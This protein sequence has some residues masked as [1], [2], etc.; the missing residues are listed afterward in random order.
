[1][2]DRV[3]VIGTGVTGVGLVAVTLISDH[4]VIWK[5]RSMAGLHA[6]LKE[7][8]ISLYRMLHKNMEQDNAEI[9]RLLAGIKCTTDYVDLISCNLVLESVSE[10]ILIKRQVIEQVEQVCNVETVI[11][12]NTSSLLISEIA[13][14]S[15]IPE[16]I[17]GMHFFNP[18]QKMRLVEL[19]HT[20][21]TDA[22]AL[23]CAR[24]YIKRVNKIHINALD[25]SGFVVNRLLLLMLNEACRMLEKNVASVLDIDNAMEYGAGHPMGIFALADLIGLDI[26]LAALNNLYYHYG[27]AYKPTHTLRKM[28]EEGNLGRKSGLGFHDYNRAP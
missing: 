10:D 27:N 17:I 9:K 12:S 21:K 6:G 25:S 11:A 18:I 26:C 19:V 24:E 14:H 2:E 23:T 4:E 3:G 20:D 22:A 13:K 1:M 28:V 8:E 15:K 7:V 16:R 5:S